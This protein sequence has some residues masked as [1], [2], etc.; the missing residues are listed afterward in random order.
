MQDV[1]CKKKELLSKFVFSKGISHR[2]ISHTKIS[3]KIFTV[4]LDYKIIVDESENL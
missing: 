2:K 1:L 4:Q 3:S